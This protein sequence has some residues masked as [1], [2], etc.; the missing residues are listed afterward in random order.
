MLPQQVALVVFA[1]SSF[2]DSSCLGFVLCSSEQGSKGLA[3]IKA[4]G[5]SSRSLWPHCQ[6]DGLL[7]SDAPSRWQFFFFGF[8]TR[9]GL[10]LGAARNC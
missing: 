2:E 5:A 4:Q 1:G 3:C 6:G 9:P 10:A 7:A 8:S